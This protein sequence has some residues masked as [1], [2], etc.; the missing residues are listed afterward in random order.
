MDFG[1]KNFQY[2]TDSF[3]NIVGRIQ[4]GGRLYLRSLSHSKPSESPA[5]MAEDFPGISQDFQLPEELEFV[6]KNLFSSVLR[7]S[8]RVNMWLHYDVSVDT[9]QIQLKWLIGI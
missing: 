8:G 9:G 5:N 4:K 7:L 2:I 1:A 6:R 3:A